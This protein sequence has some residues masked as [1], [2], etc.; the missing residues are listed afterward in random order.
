[1]VRYKLACIFYGQVIDCKWKTPCKTYSDLLNYLLLKFFDPFL[2]KKPDYVSCSGELDLSGLYGIATS[3]CL[4]GFDMVRLYF[5]RTLLK[6][7]HARV[8]VCLSKIH[9][10]EK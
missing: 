4:I 3:D 5:A 10:Q 2:I 6:P 9:N 8:G 7:D 1:M